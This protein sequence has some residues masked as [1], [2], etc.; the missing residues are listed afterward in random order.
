MKDKRYKINGIILNIWITRT[1][2]TY[3]ILYI[4][5]YGVIKGNNYQKYFSVS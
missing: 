3:Y 4:K 2:H 1:H 5:N